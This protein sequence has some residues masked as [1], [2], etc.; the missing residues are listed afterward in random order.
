[1]R[2]EISQIWRL[3]L[4]G[5]PFFAWVSSSMTR[6]RSA[7]LVVSPPQ[8]TS[9]SAIGVPPLAELAS[10]LLEGHVGEAARFLCVDPA[11]VVVRLG[12]P[13]ARVLLEDARGLT[14]VEIQRLFELGMLRNRMKSRVRTDVIGKLAAQIVAEIA[15]REPG[16]EVP[17]EHAELFLGREARER[18]P[19]LFVRR[20]E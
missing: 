9:R 11:F 8:R 18:R 20:T 3:T 5:A 6:L 10:H 14:A 12:E 1:M 16:E 15:P 17:G 13:L 7:L 2:E 19:H 4:E